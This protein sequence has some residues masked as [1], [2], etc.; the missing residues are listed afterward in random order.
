MMG[1]HRRRFALLRLPTRSS[2][3]NEREVN[4]V[5]MCVCSMYYIQYVLQYVCN[6]LLDIYVCTTNVR[7]RLVGGSYIVMSGS[8]SRHL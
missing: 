6:K 2:Y 5:C 7:S 3:A 8:K 4:V 1:G